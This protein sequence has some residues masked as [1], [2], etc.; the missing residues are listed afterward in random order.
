MM[1][2]WQRRPFGGVYQRAC[3][4][5]EQAA[6][7]TGCWSLGNKAS[8]GL[9]GWFDDGSGELGDLGIGS[10]SGLGVNQELLGD[11]QV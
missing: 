4:Q 5:F 9:M 2:Q 7:L 10:L 6:S 3:E 8:V 1:R 11:E